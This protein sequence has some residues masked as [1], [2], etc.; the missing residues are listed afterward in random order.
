VIGLRTPP[1]WMSGGLCAQADPEVWFPDKGGASGPAKRVCNGRPATDVA[2]GREPCPVRDQ[3]L[4][5]ALDNDVR[6]GIWGGLSE[7]ERRSLIRRQQTRQA[8]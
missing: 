3:C 7:K 4:R 1:D 5:Y 6:F 2:E 8:A